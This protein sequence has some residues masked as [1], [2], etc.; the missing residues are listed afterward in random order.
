[1]FDE[2][3]G[4]SYIEGVSLR[5]DVLRT[6]GQY[7]EKG[8]PHSLAM[9]HL[10]YFVNSDESFSFE[11]VKNVTDL[12]EFRSVENLCMHFRLPRHLQV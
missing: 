3:Y 6:K 12:S 2:F 8:D 1:M 4:T 7:R 9:I 11:L 5:V 10:F